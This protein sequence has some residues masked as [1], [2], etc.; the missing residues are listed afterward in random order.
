MYICDRCGKVID[1]LEIKSY[2][3]HVDGNPSMSGYMNEIM[4]CTCG[5][6]FTEAN[7]C[8]HCGKIYDSTQLINNILCPECL[9]Q[10]LTRAN[11]EYYARLNGDYDDVFT[12][13]ETEEEVINYALWDKESFIEAIKETVLK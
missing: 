10:Y 3:H 8:Q 12:G 13:E 5:G 4:D 7:I 6:Q 2:Y 9:K 1:K 11:I